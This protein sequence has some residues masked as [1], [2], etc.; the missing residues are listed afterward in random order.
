MEGPSIHLAA[1]QLRPFVA[2]RVS[3]VSGNSRI[4]IG[5][6]HGQEVKDIFAW[7][8]HLVFQFDA[9]AL[10]VH[11]M[12]WG[13]FGQKKSPARCLTPGPQM[14]FDDCDV[15]RL[16]FDVYLPRPPIPRPAFSV[17]GG[18]MFFARR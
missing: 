1:E 16:T 5:R 7:G 12:L 17:D 3:A 11:F 2:R 18:T 6:F 10:R 15:R 9:F 13:T 14:T 4:G 8:K